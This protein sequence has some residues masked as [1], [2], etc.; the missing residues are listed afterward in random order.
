MPLG[1]TGY[2]TSDLEKMQRTVIAKAKFTREHQGLM[3][4]LA[5]RFELGQGE[6]TL[7]I[8]K[9]SSFADAED[10]SDGVDMTSAQQIANT[11]TDLTC[12]E[13]GVKAIVTDKLI[14]QMNESVF[15][16][17]GKLLGDSMGRKVEKDG[18]ALFDG[19]STSLGAA[20]TAITT[21]YI[22]TA[23]TRLESGVATATSGSTEPAPRPYAYVG[24]PF[25]VKIIM[26]SVAKVGTYPLPEGWSAQM[27][28][29]Y[30]K[31]SFDIYG[32]P[33]FAQ[34]LLTIDASADCKGAIFSKEAIGYIVA[35]EAYTERQR[36]ASLRA[37]ELVHVQDSDWAEIDDGYGIEMYFDATTPTS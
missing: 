32:L 33:V 5:T 9:M 19:F 1:I 16:M 6:K 8:P 20:G 26:D 13:I 10:L 34:G 15:N 25:Q 2:S 12:S 37:W 17:C 14:R 35:K 22:A 36:D 7:T 27:L 29:D 28:R 30:W 18:N 23:V 11:Y 4:G 31:G 24:H 3:I 21:G